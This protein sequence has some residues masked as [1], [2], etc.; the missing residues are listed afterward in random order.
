L[1]LVHTAKLS[2]EDYYHPDNHLTKKVIKKPENEVTHPLPVKNLKNNNL[3]V[4]KNEKASLL[5]DIKGQLSGKK[6]NSFNL[7]DEDLNILM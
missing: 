4:V 6:S 7:D 2:Q 1:G 3:K 5:S